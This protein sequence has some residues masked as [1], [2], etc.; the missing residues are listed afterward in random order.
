MF[1]ANLPEN[2]KDSSFKFEGSKMFKGIDQ[3]SLEIG[4]ENL[5]SLQDGIVDFIK[6]VLEE[7]DVLL[8][9]N[10]HLISNLV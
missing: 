6:S 3:L 8:K 7:R 9:E 10:H 5:E 2:S 4:E 1:I